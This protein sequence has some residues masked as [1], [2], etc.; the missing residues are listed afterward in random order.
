MTVVGWRKMSALVE[1]VKLAKTKSL[2][3]TC[4]DDASDRVK[5]D[6]FAEM[7]V[8]MQQMQIRER[9]HWAR[10]LDLVETLAEGY[11]AD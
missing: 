6:P 4:A 2:L 7:A 11:D 10:H 8:D 5:C 1:K 9:G 3:G